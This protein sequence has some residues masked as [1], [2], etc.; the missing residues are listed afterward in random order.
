MQIERTV[1]KD[2]T[3]EE[4]LTNYY[5]GDDE[6]FTE[7]DNRHR[8]NLIGSAFH[9]L[10]FRQ[11]AR[12]ELANDFASDTLMNVVR[13][14]QRPNA[15]WNPQRGPVAPWLFRMLRNRVVSFQRSPQGKDVLDTDLRSSQDGQGSS[16]WDLLSS[17]E[18]SPDIPPA[19][20]DERLLLLQ[21][22]IEQLPQELQTIVRFKYWDDLS[23]QEIADR[24]GSSPATISRRLAKAHHIL[25]NALAKCAL[26]A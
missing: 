9:R 26:S 8:S 17:K 18:A 22:V 19:Q 23:H 14:K 3:D 21:P 5:A 4:L 15:R 25:R 7:F 20:D 12:Q 2:L 13:T 24:V 16:V 11:G 6:A 1:L 10:S